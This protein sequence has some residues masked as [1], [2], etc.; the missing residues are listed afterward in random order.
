MHCGKSSA[1]TNARQASTQ[2]SIARSVQDHRKTA[3]PACHGIGKSWSAARIAAAFL[4][5]HPPGQATVVT[6]APTWH[7]VKNI[8]WKEL[9]RAQKKADLPGRINLNCEWIVGDGSSPSGASPPTTTSTAS[10]ASTPRFLLV[11]VD[12]ACGVVGQIWTA[13]TSL[14]T[15]DDCRVLALGNPD[16]PNSE[17]AHLCKGADPEAAA[18]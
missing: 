8:L 14:M 10:K 5:L 1:V 17:F 13:V 15:N 7:Q 4:T 16:D 11:I 6:T 18:S 2:A 12:E 9:R 3:V